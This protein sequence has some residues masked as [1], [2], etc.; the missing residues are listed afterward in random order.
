MSTAGAIWSVSMRFRIISGEPAVSLQSEN[1]FTFLTILVAVAIVGILTLQVV[2]PWKTT[3]KID[4]EEE[5]LFRGKAIR[6]GIESYYKSAHAG[7][8]RFPER[9]EDLIGSQGI[10]AGHFVR[11]LY[12][13]PITN[14]D[15]ELI[16][17]SGGLLKGVHSKSEEEPI[18]KGNFPKEFQAFEGKTRYS[19]WLFVY[20]PSI[21]KN[22]P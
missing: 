18:K 16:Y 5:L 11:R 20:D 9:L 15:W 17:D 6:D 22:P 21:D 10:T 4:Q 19:D 12:N 1:G 3:K 13:D 2:A 7:F 8:N 14:G